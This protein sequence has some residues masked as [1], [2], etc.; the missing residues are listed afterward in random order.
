[1]LGA[2]LGTYMVV[3]LLAVVLGVMAFILVV[4]AFMFIDLNFARIVMVIISVAILIS[5]CTSS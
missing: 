4:L 3:G 5:R 2:A 1:M